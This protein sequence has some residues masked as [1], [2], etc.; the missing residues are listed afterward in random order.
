MRRYLNF[1]DD[2]QVSGFKFE[3]LPHSGASA[4]NV[5]SYNS[6]TRI[7]GAQPYILF[8][9][10]VID[11][12]GGLA[13]TFPTIQKSIY[14]DL[15]I[16]DDNAYNFE[17]RHIRY[18]LNN[19][20]CFTLYIR[21]YSYSS[22]QD[23]NLRY[24][25]LPNS[26][27]WDL[28]NGVKDWGG[29]EVS[30]GSFNGLYA[31]IQG[32]SIFVTTTVNNG[33][34]TC[35][36]TSSPYASGSSTIGISVPGAIGINKV[37]YGTNAGWGCQYKS[38]RLYVQDSWD[39]EFNPTSC[40]ITW[41]DAGI[42][43]GS[44][45]SVTVTCPDSIPAGY[46]ARY[47]LY[48]TGGSA[49][50]AVNTGNSYTF[51]G[52]P[53]NTNYTCLVQGYCA[54]TGEIT[55]G[56]WSAN[57]A[58]ANRNIPQFGTSVQPSL[59]W[60]DGGPNSGRQR[61][62]FY[63]N[64][65]NRRYRVIIHNTAGTW[66]YD[67]GVII[68]TGANRE[69]SIYVDCN[70]SLIV[71]YGIWDDQGNYNAW[72]YSNY[73]NYIAI[74]ERRMPDMPSY[75]IQQNLSDRVVVT[76]GA[77]S[78]HLC[79]EVYGAGLKYYGIWPGAGNGA[80]LIAYRADGDT[81]A[82]TS[83]TISVRDS[84]TSPNRNQ[85]VVSV[86]FLGSPTITKN[87]VFK[88]TSGDGIN[89]VVVDWGAVTGAS[90]YILGIYNG[91]DY[92]TWDMG[93]TQYFNT[94][95]LL[96]FPSTLPNTTAN[97]FNHTRT[98]GRLRSSLR[99]MYQRIPNSTWRNAS[100]I[101]HW[102]VKSVDAN[103]VTN[104]MTTWGSTVL[105]D[106][107]K[108]YPVYD[109][110]SVNQYRPDEDPEHEIVFFNLYTNGDRYSKLDIDPTATG[111]QYNSD[112]IYGFR[113]ESPGV[114][115]YEYVSGA[116]LTYID[117]KIGTDNQWMYIYNAIPNEKRPYDISICDSQ[118]NWSDKARFDMCPNENPV[119]DLTAEYLYSTQG[120]R[121]VNTKFSWN[122][123]GNWSNSQ[124]RLHIHNLSNDTFVITEV[125][126][127]ATEITVVLDDNTEYSVKVSIYSNAKSRW[128]SQ[129]NAVWTGNTP[130]K[131]APQQPSI[132]LE[133][134]DQGEHTLDK[135]KVKILFSDLADDVATAVIKY[136]GTDQEEV[137]TDKLVMPS[138][139]EIIIE[140]IHD[141]QTL[142]VSA[143]V[144][145][146]SDNL[147]VFSKS[148][149]IDIP[150][151]TNPIRP[152]LSSIE[153]VD[154]GA[155]S[156]DKQSVTVV[157][158]IFTVGQL[159]GVIKTEDGTELST[160]RRSGSGS[161]SFVNLPDDCTL[162]LELRTMDEIGLLSEITKT[163]IK[164]PNR[165]APEVIPEKEHFDIFNQWNMTNN[166][167]TQEVEYHFVPRQPIS[168]VQIKLVQGSLEFSSVDAETIKI[169]VSHDK[170]YEVQVTY[171]DSENN[172]TKANLGT[173]S[174]PYMD[175]PTS[176]NGST[177]TWNDQ[178]INSGDTQSITVTIPEYYN[179]SINSIYKTIKL[180]SD[181]MEDI[182]SPRLLITQETYTFE[183]LEDDRR[184]AMTIV[185][186]DEYGNTSAESDVVYTIVKDR[187]APDTPNP[188]VV[189]WIDQGLNSSNTQIITAEPS[190]LYDNSISKYQ[191]HFDMSVNGEHTTDWLIDNTA[192]LEN[193]HDSQVI[194]VKLR[195]MD[196]EG[197]YSEWSEDSEALVI[198]D[199]VAPAEP[200]VPK[201][202]WQDQG[203][204]SSNTQKIS[205]HLTSVSNDA[206]YYEYKLISSSG[207]ELQDRIVPVSSDIFIFEE[208]E[209]N[210]SVYVT[211][212]TLDEAGNYSTPV[213]SNT[214]TIPCRSIPDSSKITI[215]A[216]PYDYN[217]G[218]GWL[219]ISGELADNIVRAEVFYA[220]YDTSKLSVGASKYSTLEWVLISTWDSSNSVVIPDL[221][222]STKYIS[223]ILAYDSEGN[224]ST[225]I[226]T[227]VTTPD[228]TA[229]VQPEVSMSIQSGEPNSKEVVIVLSWDNL[230]DSL[231]G[232]EVYDLT[233][234]LISSRLDTS[235][236]NFLISDAPQG[237]EVMYTIRRYDEVG[238]YSES[239]T[240]TATTPN[241]TPQFDDPED[242]IIIV[243][244]T[245]VKAS[246][247]YPGGP[248]KTPATSVVFKV[249]R[250]N[251]DINY[252]P[253]LSNPGYLFTDIPM[254][255]TIKISAIVYDAE[256]NFKV[257]GE[258][259]IFVNCTPS[260]PVLVYPVD[261]GVLYNHT[262]TFKMTVPEDEDNEF[263]TL[264]LEIHNSTGD[265][266]YKFTSEKVQQGAD[267]LLV[268]SGVAL[269]DGDYSVTIYSFDD[270]MYSAK[271]TYSFSIR[272]ISPEAESV[273]I[274][275]KNDS[276]A[277]PYVLISEI[278]KAV[279]LVSKAYGLR[280]TGIDN[281]SLSTLASASD[282]IAAR[283]CVEALYSLCGKTLEWATPEII[284]GETIRKLLDWK[285]VLNSLLVL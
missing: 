152:S 74:P 234:N 41:N 87:D 133:W 12:F 150:N 282:I 221:K 285:E 131:T 279:N 34:L 56:V 126:K 139:K 130:D 246:I 145:D 180:S 250:E 53:S 148:V 111:G 167:T 72:R 10:T 21:H 193:L 260:I 66:L 259:E 217:T 233:G 125:V 164:I 113:F 27:A 2:S 169:E 178:G 9:P 202:S 197:N 224:Y 225:T 104:P 161:L 35:T 267:S 116:P 23:G 64:E 96:F 123:N 162:Y 61:V 135:Q 17:W 274:L 147:S 100:Y 86:S 182:L 44:T 25:E 172:Y 112:G 94:D 46:Y 278:L 20:Q 24:P 82:S 198:P 85:V 137:T 103:G 163:S 173:V 117:K 175:A 52:L 78:R 6:I 18:E 226:S 97:I 4:D 39:Y 132:S 65:L 40:G 262:P 141:S 68:D 118:R 210:Q 251:G 257:T 149:S 272:S 253:K 156:G 219:E 29:S 60:I 31:C 252:S 88:S 222:D 1:A 213:K 223:K 124:Y 79:Y 55:G 261:S 77:S 99:E 189:S 181:E 134:L 42:N 59:N 84:D 80:T 109:Y 38:T 276:V 192:Q 216:N 240:I 248:I 166:S 255:E 205:V 196:R 185:V 170:T 220:V 256:D 63:F 30:H 11:K 237:Y 62:S 268:T 238:N 284:Q 239:T 264:F 93:K 71:A 249:I 107:D 69:H 204:N 179:T 280:G 247:T 143:Q 3:P 146:D 214:V 43:S 127:S 194:K 19:G 89:Q 159:I 231:G 120:S 270:N 277:L 45:Q 235:V 209:D 81:R 190:V 227:I 67:S 33:G 203:V 36:I 241:R 208:V 228:R 105:I 75:S 187:T 218:K 283:T 271:D 188:P 83:V 207:I 165:T 154:G 243:L 5:A 176:M 242:P 110:K 171:Y 144:I 14:S 121:K 142:T 200:S 28:Y 90:K 281:I 273:Y 15:T 95:T 57:C 70:Q 266:V 91:Y 140:D 128:V 49:I 236:T 115:T 114:T 151:R 73:G 98:G 195:I 108:P 155:N 201:I 153:F 265:L 158:N 47:T 258:Q 244:G 245:G 199:R 8:K 58:V 174:I 211:V 50:A 186:S 48:Y 263:I 168:N 37:I 183:N 230:A 51:T 26:V 119:L 206:D 177:A 157:A 160:Q 101:L 76:M 54:A 92:E 138:N 7:A 106:N 191:Y 229:P 32:A 215:T 129:E 136:S 212:A 232:Y 269:D 254:G 102:Y 13:Y 122:A 16:H 275:S 184:Y 22:A